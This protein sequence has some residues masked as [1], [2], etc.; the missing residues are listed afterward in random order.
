M[1]TLNI[2]A[3]QKA[4]SKKREASVLKAQVKLDKL[5]K[6]LGI[7]TRFKGSGNTKGAKTDNPIEIFQ[8]VFKEIAIEIDRIDATGS[9]AKEMKRLR[10]AFVARADTNT[11]T[12]A[13]YSAR[14]KAAVHQT[15]ANI[16]NAKADL[17]STISKGAK[18]ATNE[19][20]FAEARVKRQLNKLD[21]IDVKKEV[22]Q[23]TAVGIKNAEKALSK[24]T[25][26][27][28][29]ASSMSLKAIT[30]L[31][32]TLADSLDSV[33]IEPV[34]DAMRKSLLVTKNVI[35]QITTGYSILATVAATTA[36]GAIGTFKIFGTLESLKVGA[37]GGYT[38]GVI[39]SI[40]KAVALGA[41]KTKRKVK[42]TSTKIINGVLR[43]F[44]D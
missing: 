33:D 8:S 11:R 29:E 25:K 23:A 18:R 2:A 3:Q 16:K 37:S 1:P 38:A 5:R 42:Y 44:Y 22:K 26:F 30:S 34:K 13:D 39:K 7:T 14:I 12:L 24:I 20:S 36:K 40:P 17:E 10:K 21:N 19:A 32:D 4:A 27:A 6:K 31:S 41:R 15:T 28:D 9:K 43:Y 35:D